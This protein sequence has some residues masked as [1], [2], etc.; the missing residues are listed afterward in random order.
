M[1]NQDTGLVCLS[2]LAIRL[3]PTGAGWPVAMN[4]AAP[5][6]GSQGVAIACDQRFLLARGPA[7]Q[8]ALSSNRVRSRVVTFAVHDLHRSTLGRVTTPTSVVMR[9]FARNNVVSVSN[10]ERAV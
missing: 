7:L 3:T 2:F 8:L 1:K 10:V 6:Q 4:L 5:G 9:L